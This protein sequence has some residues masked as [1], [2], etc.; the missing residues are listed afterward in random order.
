MPF[1]LFS[2]LNN[3]PKNGGKIIAGEFES[4][5]VPTAHQVKNYLDQQVSAPTDCDESS[6]PTSASSTP[7]PRVLATGNMIWEQ[8]WSR[9]IM[10]S[11][12][13]PH[14]NRLISGELPIHQKD[15]GEIDCPYYNEASPE[16]KKQFWVIFMASI[17]KAESNFNKGLIFKEKF[18]GTEST[19]LLQINPEAADVHCQKPEG[20]EKFKIEHMKD[21]KINLRCGLQIMKNQL[22]GGKT[23]RRADTKGHLF[24]NLNSNTPYYWSVLHSSKSSQV[25]EHFKV[26]AK[27]QLKFCTDR[28]AATNAAPQTN[29]ALGEASINPCQKSVHQERDTHRDESWDNV[30]IEEGGSNSR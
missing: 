13:R 21:P 12:N 16:Q 20:I 29:R 7:I 3:N 30:R 10:T 23:G 11:L 19:G 2:C 9:E 28:S 24:T 15:L 18:D 1:L 27:H 25:K 17:A 26:H 6:S 22:Q 8:D 5:D 14:L 4:S